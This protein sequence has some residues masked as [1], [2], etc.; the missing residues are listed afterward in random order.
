[1]QLIARHAERTVREAL[2][3]TRIVLV[4]G[5]RQVG[6]STLTRTVS[7]KEFPAGSD[8]T[9]FD[10]TTR[11]AATT[12]STS[13]VAGL[14]RPALI[15]EIQRAPDLILA[16]TDAVD[17][18]NAPGQF[19]LTGSANILTTKRTFESMSGRAELVRLYPLC[20][21]EIEGSDRNAVDGLLAGLVPNISGAPIG[22]EAFVE[23][24]AAG[25]YPEVISRKPARRAPWFRDYLQ[26]I[27]ERDLRDIATATKAQEMMPLL[28]LLSSQAA[29]LLDYRRIARDLAITDKTVKAYVKLLADVFLVH[30][31]RPWRPGL[32]RREVH[33]PKPLIVDS[34]LLAFL[35]GAEETR[36][37]ED[38]QVTGKT[39]E[40]FCAMEIVKHAA[41]SQVQPEVFHYRDGRDEVDL[42]IESRSGAVAC[43]EVKAAASVTRADYAVIAK[44]RDRLGGRFKAGVVLYSGSDTVPLADR[45][46]ALP[47]SGLWAS[48]LGGTDRSHRRGIEELR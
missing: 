15:D 40:T 3:D 4:L 43:V 23:R 46:W 5:A 36:I 8:Y 21:S 29:N 33:K 30:V 2:T 31:L 47:I 38:D 32:G 13:F 10:Q 35:L 39:L 22:R 12:D 18:D 25:G 37:A 16:I 17:R 28:R 1:M 11:L 6:K 41:W 20:Q 34:G 14:T 44:L 45:I 19:L 7:E 42:V 24:V 48:G 27:V 26:T 9:L